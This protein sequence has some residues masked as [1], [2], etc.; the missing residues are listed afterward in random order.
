[1]LMWLRRTVAPRLA[2]AVA[3]CVLVPTLALAQP[4]D[5]NLTFAQALSGEK[6]PLTLSLKRAD[7]VGWTLCTLGITLTTEGASDNRAGG[8]G[9]VYLTKFEKITVE[10]QKYL[11][12][13]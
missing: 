4:P 11:V 8:E 7:L 13:Y 3:L 9:P 2:G 5:D 6:Y 12:A 1:M 10:G